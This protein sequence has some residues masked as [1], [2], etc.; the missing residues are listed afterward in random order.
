MEIIKIKK[1]FEVDIHLTE[2]EVEILI[3]LFEEICDIKN[4]P[5]EEKP[6]IRKEI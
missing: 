2:K 3:K 1:P 6:G 4:V 5:F